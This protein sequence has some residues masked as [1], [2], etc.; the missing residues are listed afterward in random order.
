M[1]TIFQIRRG[2]TFWGVKAASPP[3]VFGIVVYKHVVW[4]SQHVAIHIDCCW[5]NNLQKK[6]KKKTNQIL[7]KTLPYFHK[8]GYRIRSSFK[9][10]HHHRLL[11]FAL[12][13]VNDS[14]DY[15]CVYVANTG[16]F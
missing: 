11:L 3:P 13:K 9:T 12:N 8:R 10:K 4:D 16:D 15:I 1:P 14:Y 7:K 2:R 5:Y 6:T